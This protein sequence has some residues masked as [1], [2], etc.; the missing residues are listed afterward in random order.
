M[1]SLPE[2]MAVVIDYCHLQDFAALPVV[3][4]T[5]ERHG[6]GLTVHNIPSIG[7]DELFLSD[8]KCLV[9]KRLTD[10]PVCLD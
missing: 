2:H 8:I 10:S 9:S 3:R 4:D 1:L 6:Q 7:L 5:C